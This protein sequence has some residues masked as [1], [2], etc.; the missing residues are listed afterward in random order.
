MASTIKV[1]IIG[2]AS[3]LSKAFGQAAGQASTF[4]DKLQ[5]V[6]TKMVSAGKMLTIGLTLPIVAFAAASVKALVEWEKIGAQ[7]EAVIKST[8]GAAN[9]A[10][11]DVRKYA[12]AIESVSGI[13]AEAIA[14]GENLL[15]TFTNIRNEVGAG[16]DIFNQATQLMVD[17]SVAMDQDMSTSAVQLGKALQDPIRGLTSLQRV[18]VTFTEQQKEQIK[19]M[20]EAGNVMGAQKIIL[21]ELT[22]EFGGSA[23]ALGS[24]FAG[25]LAIAKDAIGDVGEAIMA[26]LLPFIRQATT[27]VAGFVSKFDELSPQTQKIAGIGAGILAA[28]GPVLVVV[29]TLVRS[30]ATIGPV[31]AAIASPVGLVVAAIAALVAGFIL[32]Y[33]HS[34]TFRNAINGLAPMFARL[35]TAIQELAT[36]ALEIW[37]AI[38]PTLGPIVEKALVVVVAMVERHMKMI[39]ASLELVSALLRGDFSAA[40]NAIKSLISAVMAPIVAVVTAGWNAVR[41]A[42]SAAGSAI[43]AATTAAWNAVR[44]AIQSALAAIQAAVVS[45]WNAVRN[46]V[47][48]AMNAIRSLVTSAWAA[49]RSAIQSAVNAIRSV[50]TSAWNQIRSS[51]TSAFNSVRNVARTAW[52]AIRSVIAA[53]AGGIRSA[54][55][56]IVGA[57]NGLISAFNA[58]KGVAQSALDFA[59]GVANS[60]SN[61]IPGLQGG[62]TNFRGGLAIVG[63]HGPELVNLPRGTDVI[64]SNKSAAMV[65]DINLLPELPTGDGGGG[66]T[67]NV[68]VGG[69]VVAEHDLARYIYDALLSGPGSLNPSLWG[70]RS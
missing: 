25:Q 38:W 44:S 46:A 32:A 2:D 15:L 65:S 29:G 11:G 35:S 59:Q 9:V 20:V 16:N 54:I 30:L 60:I 24:T 55:G 7:T 69:S 13:S 64:P 36:Q 62:A 49:I 28:L 68:H 70:G 57:V 41:T 3:G 50:V 1:E 53:A 39:A 12:E 27:A 8:G 58:L 22:Q 33:T 67:V 52:N 43:Q 40:W 18:G 23:K 17:M 42:T 66:I 10:A 37:N 19:A 56:G 4:G 45:A 63:E 26:N 34:E 61:L 31:I 51:T 47:T 21:A 14:S 48:S 5:A 6:G